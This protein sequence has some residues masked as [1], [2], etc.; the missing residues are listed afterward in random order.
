[1]ARHYD[2]LDTMALFPATA[3]DPVIMD[4]TIHASAAVALG[5]PFPFYGTS[6]D[7]IWIHTDGFILFDDQSYPWPYAYDE[8]LLLRK[9]RSIAP[10]LNFGLFLSTINSNSIRIENTADYALIHWNMTALKPDDAT[11]EFALILFPDGN[12]EF[13]YH[14]N[15]IFPEAYC[16]SGISD[17]DELNYVVSDGQIKNS[18]PAES[19]YRFL[20]Q[21]FPT[22]LSL[23]EDGLLSG[24]TSH[25]HEGEMIDFVVRDVNNLSIRR[26]L[27]FYSYMAATHEINSMDDPRISLFPNP[28]RGEIQVQMNL[29]EKADVLFQMMD[30]NGKQV[31]SFAKYKLS[32]GTHHIIQNLNKNGR[33][34][35]GIYFL[36]ATINGKASQ[37]IKF[38]LLN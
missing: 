9:T 16:A 15:D 22:E 18:I 13:Y 23:S 21:A 5:F 24:I 20:P 8:H 1:M 7:S 28:G 12:I 37:A 27:S 2:L 19:K 29:N 11:I 3:G 30:Q 6:Y 32:A 35:P 31:F 33:M 38:I 14:S 34:K 36:H 26:A 4:D 25:N 17:G 10:Y